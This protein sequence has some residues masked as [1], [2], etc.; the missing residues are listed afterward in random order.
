VR[1]EIK[2]ARDEIKIARDEIK[3][4][5]DEI[6]IARDKIKF[7][8]DEIKIARDKIKIARRFFDPTR[9]NKKHF[10]NI[11]L[12]ISTMNNLPEILI[13]LVIPIFDPLSSHAGRQVPY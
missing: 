12:K 4:A 10:N 11:F 2:I 6:K 7:A 8:R 3:I 13:L 9:N 5:R 1:D